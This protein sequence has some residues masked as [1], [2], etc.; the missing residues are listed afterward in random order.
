MPSAAPTTLDH[1]YPSNRR[2]KYA[3]HVTA[4]PKCL[5]VGQSL[6]DALPSFWIKRERDKHLPWKPAEK[7]RPLLP[8]LHI[9][10][11]RAITPLIVASGLR[12]PVCRSQSRAK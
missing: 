6:R 5:S 2:S 4:P 7:A 10:E 3:A 11:A 1:I 8:E 9:P 12:G